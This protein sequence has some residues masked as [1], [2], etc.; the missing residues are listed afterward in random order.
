MPPRTE[1]LSDAAQPHTP[2]RLHLWNAFARSVRDNLL[3][4]AAV[5]VLRI[6]G[7]IVLARALRPE[8]FGL[9]KTLVIASIFALL[10]CEGGFPD[11]LIQREMLRKE[12]EVAAWW[13]TLGLAALTASALWIAA[14]LIAGVMKIPGLRPGLRLICLPLLLEGSA[15]V[16][17]SRLRR[18]LRFGAVALADVLGEAVFLATA[19]LLLA[20]GMAQWSLAGGLAA[21]LSAHAIVI[22]IADRRLSLGVPHPAA[23]RDLVRFAMGAC[24]GRLMTALSANTDYLLVGGLLG[25]AA[26]GFYSMAWDLLRFVPDRLHRVAGRVA[27]PAFCRLQDNDQEL[28][29]AYL[30]FIGYISRAV[31]P[32]LAC[33]ALAAPELIGS[34]Y[35]HRWLPAVGPMRVLSVGLILVG[36]RIGI[37]AV[38][39]TKDFPSIDIY[40]NGARLGLLTVAVFF[41]A[42]YGLLAVSAGVSLVEMLIGI[43]GQ[44]LVFALIGMK[45]RELVAAIVPSLR[46]A[47]WCILA[48]AAG[49][50]LASVLGLQP[51]LAL[52]PVVAAPALAFIWAQ[53]RDLV[54][55]ATHG[56]AVGRLFAASQQE[57]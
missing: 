54:E 34:L 15:I 38:F 55:M 24:G 8:D 10:L 17:N 47:L 3:A 32:M 27:L 40:L 52:I 33:A 19:L 53:A 21:R 51:P 31:L 7:V 22:W 50:L 16:G 5:Q 49:K 25:G 44:Y 26:L 18:E 6:G 20:R 41:M 30:N 56:F 45:L 36:L 57:G 23:A 14:P 2:A 28:G 13:L 12:H 43:A 11:A 9:L 42:P 48:T 29:R 46:L 4:E 35:G 37:G 39:Y 1:P